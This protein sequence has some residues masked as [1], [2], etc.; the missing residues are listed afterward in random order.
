MAKGIQ[1]F[2]RRVLNHLTNLKEISSFIT[3][4]DAK[5][6]NHTSRTFSENLKRD[7]LKGKSVKQ[8]TCHHSAFQLKYWNEVIIIHATYSI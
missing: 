1:L 5:L 7:L 6:I 2:P 3:V 8:E 4:E